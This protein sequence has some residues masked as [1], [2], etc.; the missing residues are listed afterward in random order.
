M[1]KK[2][3]DINLLK[4]GKVNIAE[5]VFNWAVS[6]GRVIVIIVEV[7]AL[8]AFLYRFTL[9]KELIDLHSKIKQEQAIVDFFKQNELM[10]RNLQDRLL[11]A[12]TFSD[13]ATRKNKI[14]NDL[15]SLTPA[16]IVF[17]NFSLYE[18][19]VKI[20]ANTDSVD[21]LGSFIGS[22]KTY[23]LISSISVDKIENKPSSSLITFSI[24]A[25]L[26]QAKK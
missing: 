18:D 7:V 24:T 4:T 17:N 1:A 5:Q 23:S 16:R 15:V 21:A 9:D 20:D 2:A 22:L 13:Q 3:P 11:T 10:Y 26:K 6:I 12:S 8:S 19:R 14:F 25:G